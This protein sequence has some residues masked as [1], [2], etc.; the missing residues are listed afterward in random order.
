MHIA[1]D[2]RPLIS[3]YKTGIGEYT[4]EL[5]K[6]ILTLDRKNN[7]YLFSNSLKKD[8]REIKKFTGPNVQFI[9]TNWPNKL[10][11]GLITSCR[12]PKIDTII[13]KKFNIKLDY[14]FSPNLNFNAFSKNTKFVL[15]VHD[16]SF[17][18]YP[19][20]FSTKQR[21]WHRLIKPQNQC[22]K[23]DV[24]LTPSENTKRDLSNIF[25][26]TPEKIKVIYPGLAEIFT[27]KNLSATNEEVIKKYQLPHNFIFF[28]GTSEPRKN[29]L[30]LI[31]AFES[32]EPHLDTNLVIAGAS[33]WK[34]KN[35]FKH[36]AVSKFKNKIKILDYVAPEEKPAL[37]SLA[38]VFVYPSFYEGFG[39]PVLEAMSSGVPVVTSN[40]SS[41]PEITGENAY[42]VNPHKIHEIARA[43]EIVFS[44]T[45]MRNKLINNGLEATQKYSWKKAAEEWFEA[46]GITYE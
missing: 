7:Y 22:E 28:L 8:D 41:L 24:I 21:M 37:Y 34:Q 6:A 18:I 13:N 11:N 33:G 32:V 39:F 3:P 15:T 27:N 20:F 17:K 40:R 35:I 1:I 31:K 19:Q 46:L 44:N 4:S 14:F 42:L 16:V 25:K 2:L 30:G 45:E 5:L 36:L 23:A 9:S 26:I 43:I 10:F 29:L 38:K 12:F